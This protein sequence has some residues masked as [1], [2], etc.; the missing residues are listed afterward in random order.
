MIR[1]EEIPKSLNET[2]MIDLTCWPIRNI[3]EPKGSVDFEIRDMKVSTTE[4]LRWKISG[5]DA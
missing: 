5:L 2:W 4:W 1:S 3:Q